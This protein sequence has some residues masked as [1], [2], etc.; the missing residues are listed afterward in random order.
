MGRFWLQIS[1]IHFQK[2][3]RLEW[4][5]KP[6]CSTSIIDTAALGVSTAIFPLQ[7]NQDAPT[8]EEKLVKET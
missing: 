4:G 6:E 5:V 2:K 1:R 8:A 7:E 3:A